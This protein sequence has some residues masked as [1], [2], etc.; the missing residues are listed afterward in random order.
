METPTGVGLGMD[1][2]SAGG[3]DRG[4]RPSAGG[5]S[6]GD[7]WGDVMPM[8]LP[9]NPSGPFPSQP[10]PG[11]GGAIPIQLLMA[12]AQ[13]R[14]G[15]APMARGMG[16]QIPG[17]PAPAPPPGASPGLPGAV[18]AASE[19]G[20]PSLADQLQLMNLLMKL[21]LWPMQDIPEHGGPFNIPAPDMPDLGFPPRQ[22]PNV[23]NPGQEFQ[24]FYGPGPAQAPMPIPPPGQWPR[25]P[26]SVPYPVGPLPQGRT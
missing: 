1:R 18:P 24:G 15:G 16:P 8:P 9:Q 13:R 5:L 11:G 26:A 12:L 25:P 22:D 21:G 7:T 10:M 2:L 20:K 4:R 17:L 14:A 19:I 23:T 3:P 6:Q